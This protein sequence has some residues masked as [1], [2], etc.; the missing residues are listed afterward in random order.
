[1]S[2]GLHRKGNMELVIITLIGLAGLLIG[3]TLSAYEMHQQDLLMQDQTFIIPAQCVPSPAMVL[4]GATSGYT[5][6]QASV[7]CQQH[8]YANETSYVCDQTGTLTLRCQGRMS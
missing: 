1:M 4:A 5:A 2:H 7:Q 8:G 3:G 6:S